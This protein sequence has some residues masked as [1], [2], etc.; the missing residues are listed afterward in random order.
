LF[1]AHS[2]SL[3]R[4]Q[5]LIP[6]AGKYKVCARFFHP[7]TKSNSSEMQLGLWFSYWA[8]CGAAQQL[9]VAMGIQVLVIG[10][11]GSGKST[12]GHALAEKL[13]VRYVDGDAL[14]PKANLEKMAKGTPLSDDDRDPWIANIIG[15]LKTGNV[16]IGASLL[17]RSYR[18]L[19]NKEVRRVRFAQ[20]DAPRTI[21]A[22][23]LGDG[24]AEGEFSRK[25]LLAA[26]FAIM[27]PL[28]KHEPGTRFDGTK[29]V[30]QLVSEILLDVKTH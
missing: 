11:A 3:G 9:G 28:A 1:W 10:P 21:L 18:E 30:A 26:Q 24:D 14:H 13:G 6:R 12:V 22:A 5:P 27:D 2:A 16:V 17:K 15:E 29:P 19:I 25:P 20:L 4:P 8:Q 7:E 23:R